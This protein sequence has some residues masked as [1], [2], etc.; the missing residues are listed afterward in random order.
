MPSFEDDPDDPREATRQVP[1]TTA[2]FRKGEVL[3]G[4]YR[5]EKVLGR[6]GMGHVF[7]A[8]HLDLDQMVAIKVM[9]KE[10]L[11]DADSVMRFGREAKA[12][13][14]MRGIHTARIFDVGKLE[15]GQPYMVME[16][17]EGRDLASLVDT[18]ARIEIVDAV[19]WVAQACEAVAEAHD[20]GIVHRDIKPHNLF[21][22]RDRNGRAVIK[23]LDF[24]LAKA[25]SPEKVG[26]MKET[27]KQGEFVG[28]PFYVSPEQASGKKVDHRTDVWSLGA[29]LYHLVAG[30]PPFYAATSNLVCAM[31]L[32][33]DFPPIFSRRPD[34][35][36]ALE[37]LL[38]RCMTRDLDKR[39]GSVRAMLDALRALVPA[40]GPPSNPDID[41]KRTVRMGSAPSWPNVPVT[42]L[43]PS[44]S[45][46]IA[47]KATVPMNAFA[48]STPESARSPARAPLSRAVWIGVSIGFLVATAF[49]IALVVYLT[50]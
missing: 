48:Q 12:A 32:T 49:I 37:A 22:T 16:H 40:G 28:S 50:R 34:A 2:T 33:E 31:L 45:P 1:V 35:P 17:L 3:A 13:A 20:L 27:T 7:A 25:F 38:R 43:Q 24:G 6:G 26:S 14:A 15:S 11:D 9:H 42:P 46:Q 10:M 47:V 4:K 30:V 23:V 36:P 21:L 29:T 18:G 41:S 8:M 19:E 5:I 39:L 44:S